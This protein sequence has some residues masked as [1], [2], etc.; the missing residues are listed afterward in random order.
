MDKYSKR[1][2][3]TRFIRKKT[4]AGRD[5]KKT[6]VERRE[7]PMLNGRKMKAMRSMMRGR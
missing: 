3:I 5:V 6:R 1:P 4:Y 2:K 7:R